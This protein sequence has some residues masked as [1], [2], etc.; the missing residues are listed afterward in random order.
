MIGLYK[1]QA[2]SSPLIKIRYPMRFSSQ[3]PPE[4]QFPWQITVL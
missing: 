3:F 2:V 4:N 1:F